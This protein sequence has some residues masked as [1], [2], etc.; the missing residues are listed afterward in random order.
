M[1]LSKERETFSQIVSEIFQTRF[2]CPGLSLNQKIKKFPVDLL[3]FAVIRV[4]SFW[5]LI[6]H[7]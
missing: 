4:I 1:I 6:V 3:F 2:I 5:I 7:D